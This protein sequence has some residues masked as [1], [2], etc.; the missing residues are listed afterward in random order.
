MSLLTVNTENGSVSSERFLE[1]EDSTRILSYTPHGPILIQSDADFETQVWPGNGTEETPYL[2]SNLNISSMSD[3][4]T[5]EHTTVYF[6]IRNCT[7]NSSGEKYGVYLTH[8]TNGIID[9]CIIDRNTQ[10][11]YLSY[12]NN[13]SIINNTMADI[14]FDGI[15]LKFSS[16]CTIAHNGIRNC[17][18]DGVAIISSTACTFKN[19]TFVDCSPVLYG[20][21]VELWMHTFVNNTVNSKPLGYFVGL[22]DSKIEASSYGQAILVDCLNVTLRNGVFANASVGVQLAFSKECLLLDNIISDNSE[23]LHIIYS[24]GCNLTGN[25]VSNSYGRG[26]WQHSSPFC[27][28]Y[29]NSFSNNSNQAIHLTYSN[30]CEIVQNAIL[31]GTIEILVCN[32]SAIEG[33]VISRV[34]LWESINSTV[35]NN[36]IQNSPQS[37]IKVRY[38]AGCEIQNNTVFNNTLDGIEL[39]FGINCTVFSNSVFNN[40]RSGVRIIGNDNCIIIQNNITDNTEIGINL[41]GSQNSLVHGN[42]IGGNEGGNGWDEGSNNQWDDG[43]STGNHWSDYDGYG[44]YEIPGDANSKDRYPF[45]LGDAPFLNHPLDIEYVFGTEGHTITW[46]PVDSDPELY[47]LLRN[48][49]L[50]DSGPWTSSSITV[51]IGGLDVGVHNYTL[52]VYDEQD[53]WVADTVLVDVKATNT[54]TTTTTT[55]TSTTST[56]S[57]TTEP[58]TSHTT[59][60]SE[61]DPIL[62]ILLG[63]GAI[64]AIV[65]VVLLLKIKRK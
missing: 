15:E 7:F 29:K 24:T 30:G 4:I 45:A 51:D 63:S 32:F 60:P 18:W 9:K 14:A 41:I 25:S 28:I 5:I 27:K 20:F 33:N 22:S 46:N 55:T 19:N 36:I 31:G 42:R 35:V 61:F 58:T 3:C 2:I 26:I 21:S 64:G 23:G 50:L 17:T 16:N 49:I 62:I 12:C 1:T 59:T 44:E 34:E 54:S 10:G 11:I 38:A 37:G 56:T 6:V 57:T 65:I 47:E 13:C 48:S 8:V 39:I 52:I 53:N 40:S 43:V